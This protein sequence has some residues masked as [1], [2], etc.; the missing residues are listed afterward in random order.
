MSFSVLLVE[1]LLTR[2]FSVTL[3]YHLAFL[4]V[5]LAMLGFAASGVVV[6][7]YPRRLTSL[8]AL[9]S[10]AALGLAL[11]TLAASALALHVSV[12]MEASAAD[13]ARLAL[14]YATSLGPFLAGGLAVAVLLAR[15]PER[16]HRL[17]FFDLVGAA[18][19]CVAFVPVIEMMGAPAAL[20]LAAAVAALGAALLA[21][22]GH[23]I[24]AASVAIAVALAGAAAANARLGFLDVRTTKGEAQDPPLF[25][26]WNAFSRVE[27]AGRRDA[28]ERPGP[29]ASHGFSAR[30]PRS[31]RVP[32]LYIRL[33]AGA[34]TQVTGLPDRDMNRLGH[35]GYDVTS[36]AYQ[37]RR[38]EGVLVIGPGGGRD[39]LA[40]L[41]FGSGPVTAVEVNPLVITLLRG[42]LREFSGGLYSDWPGVAVVHDDGRAFVRR[43]Q[44]RFGLIQV[45]LVDTFAASAAGAY[46][47][48]ENGLY[49]VEAM[50]DYLD[51]LAPDG[52]L[53]FSRWFGEPPV[54]PLRLVSIAGEAFARR[55][56]ADAARHVLC[57]RTLQ[58]QTGRPS[59]ATVL[60]GRRP[61]TGSELAPLASWAEAMGFAFEYRPDAP[62]G[63]GFADAFRDLLGPARGRVLA[64]WSYDATPVYD[65]RPFFFDRVPLLEWLLG[66]AGVLKTPRAGPALTLGGRTLL[67]CVVVSLL[68][69]LLMLAL[70]LILSQATGAALRLPWV[71]YFLCL[72]FGFIVVEVTLIQRL[73]LVLGYPVYALSVVLFTLLVTSGLGS[74]LAGRCLSARLPAL[75]IALCLCLG[76][77]VLALPALGGLV[78]APP[79]VRI[80][81]VAGMV[82]PLGLLMGMPFPSGL[83]RAS[84][85]DPALVGWAWAVNG[86]ASVMGSVLSV[87]VAMTAGFRASLLAALLAYGLA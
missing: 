14:L 11:G 58:E 45:S 21:P 47:L 57:V 85:E 35:L 8:P 49:T 39:V 15:N 13:T 18:L 74:H 81:S 60:I 9:P 23:R 43:S 5:S 48:V 26:A 77:L 1:L 20:M 59:V 73:T 82:A 10:W 65:D 40:A 41:H 64:D 78:V 63:V 31:L 30:L 4:V 17:Y 67:F 27:L 2:V 80:V 12:G 24:G 33:D 19:A 86:A 51:H 22:R 69:T 46:A 53:S 28:L 72:G 34:A 38:H 44:A 3:H 76:A 32:E 61:F 6:G 29:P 66:R 68:A 55:G 56:V 50:E 83:R 37:L 36:A 70:P 7:L 84:A 87:V 42:P 16:T 52:V 71:L 25:A 62:G 79:L 54:E 75:L